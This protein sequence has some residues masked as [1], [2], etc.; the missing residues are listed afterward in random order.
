MSTYYISIKQIGEQ[1]FRVDNCKSKVEAIRKIQKN[2]VLDEDV[3]SYNFE[4]INILWS[5]AEVV[6]VDDE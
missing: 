2:R 4:I 3:E 1:M 5:T 6:S